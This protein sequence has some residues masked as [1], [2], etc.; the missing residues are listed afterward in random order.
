MD[1]PEY[2]H[3]IDLFTKHN[4]AL[5]GSLPSPFKAITD[6]QRGNTVFEKSIKILQALNSKGFGKKFQ[7]D[8]V[9]NPSGAYLPPESGQLEKE[10]REILNREYNVEF[11]NLYTLVNVPIKRF[12]ESLAEKGSLSQLFPALLE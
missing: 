5:I 10:Y 4:I 2:N 6:S 11:N 9:Y 1:I 7:L 8:L 3:Y 12:R